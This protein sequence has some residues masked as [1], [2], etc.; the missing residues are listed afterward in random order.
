M[1]A[2][3]GLHTDASFD[4]LG[5]VLCQVQDGKLRV[6]SY[7]SRKLKNSE[8]NYPIHKLEFLAMKWAICD[9]FNDYLYGHQFKVYTDN[10]PLSY[11]L[12][13]AKLDAT[14][15]RWLAEL[16]MYDFSIH[17]RSGK[18]NT[19]ADFLSRIP[20]NIEIETTVV[21]AFL[22]VPTTP[23]AVLIGMQGIQESDDLTTN[24]V[25]EDWAEKQ[26][27]DAD[28]KEET[29]DCVEEGDFEDRSLQDENKLPKGSAVALEMALADSGLWTGSVASTGRG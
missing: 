18:C 27:K 14:G 21:N 13:S 24:Y 16:G 22:Q 28:I 3:L 7:A 20:P 26:H 19:D 5:A 10:N 4:G 2:P 12:T 6:I 15:H 17:Y 1:E 9:K 25:D 11:V 8:R 23:G 29:T